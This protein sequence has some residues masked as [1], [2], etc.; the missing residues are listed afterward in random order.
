MLDVRLVLFTVGILVTRERDQLSF[1]IFSALI[2]T[3]QKT[4]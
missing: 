2:H 1:A 4:V 3:T